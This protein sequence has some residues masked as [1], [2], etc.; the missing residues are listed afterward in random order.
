MQQS[1]KLYFVGG[2]VWFRGA[3]WISIMDSNLVLY[4]VETN[5]N[6]L[7]G[8]QDGDVVWLIYSMDKLNRKIETMMPFLQA[9]EEDLRKDFSE[10]RTPQ[11][12]TNSQGSSHRAGKD[13]KT[14][15]QGSG[16]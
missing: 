5:K 10:E 6:L 1:R 15:K 3:D 16:K 13:R 4:Y 14:P 11:P 2:T 7:P 8:A 9:K 12:S